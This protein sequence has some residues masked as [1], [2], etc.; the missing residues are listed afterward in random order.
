MTIIEKISL[1]SSIVTLISFL[2]FIIGKILA[3]KERKESIIS[4]CDFSYYPQ[5]QDEVYDSISVHPNDYNG[6]TY[7]KSSIGLKEIAFYKINDDQLN[8]LK[9]PE[10]V[11]IYDR[12]PRNQ[13][14]EVDILIPEGATLYKIVAI[15]DDNV[16]IEK[17]LSYN[18]IGY[19][20]YD[21]PQGHFTL[22]SYL[23]YLFK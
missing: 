10:C 5:N 11:A 1:W 16:I 6:A 8:P 22:K 15:R 20:R 18:G 17:D 21:M 2:I 14:L 12:L 13:V 9:Q 23:Y 3:I 19:K 4:E 7:V